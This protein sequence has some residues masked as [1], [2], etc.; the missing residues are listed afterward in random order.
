M[1]VSIEFSVLLTKR[2]DLSFSVSNKPSSM[3]TPYYSSSLKDI[4]STSQEEQKNV[5]EVEE[6][7]ASKKEDNDKK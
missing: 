3:L 6:D 5:G 4:S 1:L 2:T 7:E